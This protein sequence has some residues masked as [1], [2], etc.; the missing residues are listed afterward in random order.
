MRWNPTVSQN[1]LIPVPARHSTIAIQR[2]SQDSNMADRRKRSLKRII[3]TKEAVVA[4]SV[5]FDATR[6]K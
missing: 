2:P 4:F 6:E 3:C 1:D 5:I